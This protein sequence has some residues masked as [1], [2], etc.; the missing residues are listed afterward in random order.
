MWPS[1]GRD[2]LILDCPDSSRYDT[3][4]YR[5]DIGLEDFMPTEITPQLPTELQ[6]EIFEL[7]ARESSHR[8]AT[9]LQVS[10]WVYHRTLP[11]LYEVVVVQHNGFL[12]RVFYPPHIENWSSN[13]L[14]FFTQYGHHVRYLSITLVQ[15]AEQHIIPV[16]KLCPS[17]RNLISTTQ[18]TTPMIDV[19][20]D[21]LPHL[22][23]LSGR[24]EDVYGW[25][26]V[27]KLT[28]RQLTHL[29]LIGLYSW[30]VWSTIFTGLP[31][32]THLALNDPGSDKEADETVLGV[33][34]SC[35]KLR[36]L[37]LVTEDSGRTETCE[38][39]YYEPNDGRVVIVSVRPLQDWLSGVRSG[40]D[41]WSL[42]DECITERRK[43]REDQGGHQLD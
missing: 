19:I 36:A 7:A 35:K 11:I 33:L 27:S 22:E 30:G 34:R 4:R 20:Q 41:M 32:L 6:D 5:D 38:E 3:V 37:L 39:E 10:K 16:L 2:A 42:A 43:K 40:L 26:D 21:Y 8:A 14:D 15:P 29:D 31:S 9:F 25:I 17:L 18:F 23:R 24:F 13:I 1:H 28:Y 12:D